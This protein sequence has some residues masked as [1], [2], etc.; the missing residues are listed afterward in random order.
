MDALDHYDTINKAS[1]GLYKEKGSKFIAYAYPCSD[2]QS[3]TDIVEEIKEKHPKSRHICYAYRLGLN[4]QDYRYNDD[5]EPSG[6]AG[7]PIYNELLS[8][9]LS[10]T[11]IAV[12]RYFGGTKLG[13]TG[14]IRAYRAAAADSLVNTDRLTRY[15]TARMCITYPIEQMGQLYQIIKKLEAS[16]IES[17]YD[18]IPKMIVECRIS[19]INIITK[20][21]IANIH[22]YSV[23]EMDD[24]FESHLIS[25]EHIS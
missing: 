15:I 11:L 19:K 16:I 13:A 7:R 9:D 6:T 18:P 21:I 22:G 14:L 25:I 4:G 2:Q 5:G 17:L 1:E 23:E 24:S 12:V 20:T 3:F 10:D 8:Q